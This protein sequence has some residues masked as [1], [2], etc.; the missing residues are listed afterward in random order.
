M[1]CL[2]RSAD[3]EKRVANMMVASSL[4]DRCAVRN[5]SFSLRFVRWC[6]K[7]ADERESL[8][9]LFSRR[10]ASTPHF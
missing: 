10:M 3:Y 5:E 9:L 6:Q 8:R 7:I 2:S 4:S 1:I